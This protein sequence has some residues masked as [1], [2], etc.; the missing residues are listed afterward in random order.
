VFLSLGMVE[1]VLK[2]KTTLPFFGQNGVSQTGNKKFFVFLAVLTALKF[3]KSANVK[4][5]FCQKFYMGIKKRKSLMLSSNSSKIM[6][7]SSHKRNYRPKTFAYRNI[8]K[9]RQFSVTFTHDILHLARIR[10]HH[11]ILHFFIPIL[12]FCKNNFLDHIGTFC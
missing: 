10:N 9:K 12:H 7:K 11:K 5:K 1:A 8:S 2:G 3:A 6:Q 4:N